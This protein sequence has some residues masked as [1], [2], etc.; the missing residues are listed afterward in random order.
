M[1]LAYIGLGSNLGQRGRNLTRAL[2]AISATC[3]RIK[4]TSYLYESKAELVEDQPA[5]LNAAVAIETDLEPLALLRQLQAIEHGKSSERYGPRE[6]DLDVLLYGA[7]SEQI[8]LGP[9][10]V[11][12]HQ[13]AH[14]RDFVLQPL[15]DLR[16]QDVLLQGKSIGEHLKGARKSTTISVSKFNAKHGR[17]NIWRNAA[18]RSRIMGI[19]NVTPDSFSDGGQFVDPDKAFSHALQ[20]VQDGATVLDIGGESTRPG[21]DK[22][23]EA[24][25]LDRVLP[26]IERCRSSHEF[27]DVVLSIDTYKPKV[28]E[29]AA[30]A[31]IDIINDV[32][33][34]NDGV[35]EVAASYDLGVILMHNRGD[36]KIMDQLT[37]YGESG[38]VNSVCRWF[39]ERISHAITN[40]SLPRWGL[41]VDP[42]FGFAKKPSQN[43]ELLANLPIMLQHHRNLLVGTSRKRFLRK[44]M[45]FD[46]DIATCGSTAIG[47]MAGAR[48][49]RVHDVR[50]AVDIINVAEATIEH[51]ASSTA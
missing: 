34:G 32:S 9:E 50:K 15:V 26:L 27:D 36:S 2:R 30:K 38:V 12:P 39:D 28:A 23:S 18:S 13:R 33:G 47:V 5:F 14:E 24:E 25:E 46:Q 41:W 17:P 19:I 16:A 8:D 31:G 6:L 49:F 45:R 48:L 22:V 10:L 21:A 11:I 37:D 44:V 43:F 7:D 3:G 29:E 40:Y 1:V 20:L 4:D 42:G 35:L 51:S